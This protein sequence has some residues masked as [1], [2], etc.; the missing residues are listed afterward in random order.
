MIDT[1][2]EAL[3]F[4]YSFVNYERIPGWKYTSLDFNLDR[5]RD[6]LQALGNPH[7]HGSF[8]HVGGT[9]GKGSVCAKE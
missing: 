5:Y 9:N 4:L 8:V 7:K 6:F 3:R 1:Y 2:D